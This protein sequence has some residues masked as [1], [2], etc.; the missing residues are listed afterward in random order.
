MRAVPA[1]NALPT[2]AV[3]DG[4]LGTARYRYCSKV[5]F[6]FVRTI[7]LCHC[8]E[9]KATWQSPAVQLDIVQFC[10]TSYI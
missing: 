9:P 7:K 4:P 2:L 6:L 1:D 8:E 10:L 3:I 5:S